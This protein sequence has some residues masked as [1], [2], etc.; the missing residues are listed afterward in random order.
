MQKYFSKFWFFTFERFIESAKLYKID[1]SKFNFSTEK[2]KLQEFEFFLPKHEDITSLKKL[3]EPNKKKI[4]HISQILMD[5]KF[6]CFTYKEKSTGNIAY[7]R[8]L[9]IDEFYS[10]VLKEKLIF[11][12]NQAITL[13]SYTHPSYRGKRLHY[14]MNIHMIL[15]LKKNTDINIIFMVIKNFLPHLTKIPI[16]LG[17]TPVRSVLHYKNGSISH[18]LSL[19]YKKFFSS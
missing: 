6:I 7:A 16:K 19:I 9:C 12:K 18:Y 14:N 2:N 17:Y 10:G 5:E 13:D 15:W 1:I 11:D 8:W 4:D 3:Y